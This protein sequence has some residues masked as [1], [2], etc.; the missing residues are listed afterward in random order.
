MHPKRPSA[1]DNL[2]SA[3]FRRR[4]ECPHEMGVCVVVG[5]AWTGSPYRTAIQNRDRVVAQQELLETHW[6]GRV[7]EESTLHRV[8]NQLRKALDDL[9]RDPR[10]IRTISK[11]GYQA[12][13]QFRKDAIEDSRLYMMTEL[14]VL[15]S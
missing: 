1:I 8:I 11:R 7:V 5:S 2:R 13:V 3:L 9:A 12:I 4:T 10:Y 14:P 6:T 15:S